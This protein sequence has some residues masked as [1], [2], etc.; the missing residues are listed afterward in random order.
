MGV[1]RIQFYGPHF[2]EF[3]VGQAGGTRQKIDQVLSLISGVERVPEKFLKHLEGTRGLYEVRIRAG[4]QAVRIFGFFDE[5][6]SVILL[7]AFKKDSAKTPPPEIAKAL[8]L[9][10]R[11]WDEKR[12]GR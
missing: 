11:Y 3:Y 1:R 4:R 9:R 8:R 10:A 12:H 2:E 6:G 7:N 5:E